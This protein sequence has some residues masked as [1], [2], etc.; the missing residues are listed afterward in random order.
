MTTPFVDDGKNYCPSATIPDEIGIAHGGF[1]QR[2]IPITIILF[3]QLL[4]V[5]QTCLQ[6]KKLKQLPKYQTFPYYLLQAIALFATIM[7]LFKYCITAII[8]QSA[9]YNQTYCKFWSYS[10]KV[11]GYLF[12]T[13]LMSILTIRIEVIFKGSS[14]FAP[15]KKCK[16]ISLGVI[17]F[18]YLAFAILTLSNL[19]EPC[20]RVWNPRDYDNK[21]WYFYCNA[22]PTLLGGLGVLLSVLWTVITNA[23]L[24]LYFS[25]KLRKVYVS[26]LDT[27]GKNQ[28]KDSRIYII[29]RKNTVLTV[30]VIFTS[31]INWC[32]FLLMDDMEMFICLDGWINCVLVGLMFKCNERLYFLICFCDRQIV[33]NSRDVK[34]ASMD[35]Q[36]ST[37]G[38]ATASV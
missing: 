5:L 2:V 11:V 21:K 34:M 3:L 35:V 10:D 9:V 36:E 23:S 8:F 4:L 37:T 12:Q 27:S 26:M 1:Y 25:Y 15:S 38:D 16:Y 7:F 19:N 20:I 13:V 31:F 18:F 29:M 14:S 28:D 33:N 6:C 22:R 24:G 30:S 17:N 32:C